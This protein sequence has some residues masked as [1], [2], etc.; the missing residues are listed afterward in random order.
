[1]RGPWAPPATATVTS[2]STNSTRLTPLSATRSARAATSASEAMGTSARTAGKAAKEALTGEGPATNAAGTTAATGLSD[3]GAGNGRTFDVAGAGSGLEDSAGISRVIRWM[4]ESMR[5]SVGAT[6]RHAWRI[7]RAT[8][9]S[10]ARYAFIPIAS[11]SSSGSAPVSAAG[12]DGKAVLGEEA[13]FSVG[14]PT[15][16]PLGRRLTGWRSASE[17]SCSGCMGRWRCSG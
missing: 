15:R 3:G 10:P 2:P 11:R 12:E 8:S 4:M 5:G 17:R 1:M 16:G 13:R 9:R 7:L 14:A 6:T